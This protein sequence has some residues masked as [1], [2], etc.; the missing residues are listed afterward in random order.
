[1][2]I[3]PWIISLIKSKTLLII[4]FLAYLTSLLAHSAVPLWLKAKIKDFWV[5][6]FFE[7]LEWANFRRRKNHWSK[8][9]GKTLRPFLSL[10]WGSTLYHICFSMSRAS[11]WTICLRGGMIPQ[12]VRLINGRLDREY[13]KK[14]VYKFWRKSR[15]LSRPSKSNWLFLWIMI[16]A[17]YN[18][19]RYHN[20]DGTSRVLIPALI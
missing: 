14:K 13:W 8:L 11:T 4:L 2:R 1:M 15:V 19:W 17:L 18:I 12:M 16:I 5:L 20:S 6:R 10:F 3:I 7:I 9:K